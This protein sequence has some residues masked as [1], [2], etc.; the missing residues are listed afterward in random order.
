MSLCKPTGGFIF[1][2]FKRC[3]STLRGTFDEMVEIGQVGA[4]LLRSGES[5]QRAVVQFLPDVF[6]HNLLRTEK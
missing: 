2:P 4:E 6:Q 1:K 5:L 3:D